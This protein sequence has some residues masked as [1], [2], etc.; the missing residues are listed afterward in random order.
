[1]RT[2]AQVLLVLLGF[3]CVILFGR[4]ELHYYTLEVDPPIEVK[5]T[6]L[7]LSG[8]PVYMRTE[9]HQKGPQISKHKIESHVEL[10]S[11]S[12]A[13]LL[14]GIVCFRAAWGLRRAKVLTNASQ[15]P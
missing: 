6:T 1:M 7:G 5:Q 12:T 14:V 11:W 10:V 3:L 13:V 2:T 9:S 4:Y 8:S 15:Q